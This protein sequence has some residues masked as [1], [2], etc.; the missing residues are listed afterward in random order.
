M[1]KTSRKTHL[2]PGVC[3][4]YIRHIGGWMRLFSGFLGGYDSYNQMHHV[5]ASFCPC[6]QVNISVVCGTLVCASK[7]KSVT[8]KSDMSYCD[9]LVFRLFMGFWNK[10]MLYHLFDTIVAMYV[11]HHQ[12]PVVLKCVTSW[13]LRGEVPPEGEQIV[14]FMKLT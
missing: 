2:R 5:A 7:Q 3:Y 10:F 9:Q 14:L 13:P 11:R 6:L 8:T 12:R 4:T 1:A